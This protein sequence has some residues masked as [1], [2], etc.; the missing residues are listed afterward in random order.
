MS[1]LSKKY[2]RGSRDMISSNAWVVAGSRGMVGDIIEQS[3]E[4]SFLVKTDEGISRCKL[5]PK[6]TGPGQ[7]TITATHKTRGQFNITKIT[8]D[9]VWH[10]DGTTY[11]WVVSAEN[12]IGDI[13]GLVAP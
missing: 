7:M 12:A 5:V 10:P 1:R 8:E 3:G 9:L 6:L 4:N 2:F 13:V 11:E